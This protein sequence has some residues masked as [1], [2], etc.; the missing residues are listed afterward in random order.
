V[1]VLTYGVLIEVAPGVLRPAV[2]C[3]A[4][5]LTAAHAL[6]V[7]KVALYAQV[8]LLVADATRWIIPLSDEL[9]ERA[10]ESR[11]DLRTLESVRLELE[12]VLL[13]PA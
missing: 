8:E 2:A 13:Q 12:G 3:T 7:R 10:V 9:R 1:S 6:E 4:S 11:G 5:D